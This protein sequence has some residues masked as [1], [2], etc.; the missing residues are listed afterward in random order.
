LTRAVNKLRTSP[1]RR[2]I[3][4]I[5]SLWCSS[6][7]KALPSAAPAGKVRIA[8]NNASTFARMSGDKTYWAEVD[9]ARKVSASA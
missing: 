8:R 1:L 3:K 6:A 9:A 7:T 5:S 2:W 4:V